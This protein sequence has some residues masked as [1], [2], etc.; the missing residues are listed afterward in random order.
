MARNL[1][2]KRMHSE[3]RRIFALVTDAFGGRG[4]IAQYNRDFFV[5]LAVPPGKWPITILPRYAPDEFV[6]LVGINQLRPRRLQFSYIV[7]ALS[8]ALTRRTAVVLFGHV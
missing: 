2:F 3:C 1:P 7:A 4:G 5:A 8:H 6:P